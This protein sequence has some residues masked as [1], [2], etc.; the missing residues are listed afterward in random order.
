VDVAK[1]IADYQLDGNDPEVVEKV[2][3]GSY[4]TAEQAELA[5]L[6]LAYQR[7]K[8]TNPSPA[9]S[10]AIVGKPAVPENQDAKIAR[11]SQLQKEPMKNSKEI[12]KL[13]E[14]LGW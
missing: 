5:A 11:L 3:K 4:Q 1:V 9:A 12:K 13:M 2:L 8:P 10:S 14:E 6:R 7:T